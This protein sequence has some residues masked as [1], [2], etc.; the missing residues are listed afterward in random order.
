[1]SI[2]R[3]DEKCRTRGGG[4]R[5]VAYCDPDSCYNRSKKTLALR[6]QLSAR[7][8][9][10]PL[11]ALFHA[12]PLS[13]AE[14]RALQGQLARLDAY[15]TKADGQCR[16]VHYCHRTRQGCES[17]SETARAARSKLAAPQGERGRPR[18]ASAAASSSREVRRRPAAASA[19]SSSR[20]A[21][22][23]PAAAPSSSDRVRQP[24]PPRQVDAPAGTGPRQQRGLSR[25]EPGQGSSASDAR[26]ESLEDLRARAERLIAGEGTSSGSE[27]EGS[28]SGSRGEGSSSGSRGEGS[29]SG[30][31]GEG[32]SSGSRGEGS[33]SAQASADRP[34][35]IY[36]LRGPMGDDIA[37]R[38]ARDYLDE[39]LRRV[40]T[41]PREMNAAHTYVKLCADLALVPCR[42][43]R[44]EKDPYD[45]EEFSREELE[46]NCVAYRRRGAHDT[47]MRP[48]NW[49]QSIISHPRHHAIDP[50]TRELHCGG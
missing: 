9:A 23:R 29:S 13:A 4:C 38:R 11:L 17:R 10:H 43:E 21:R 24:G 15:C 22:R 39:S 18:P 8:A 27:G 5:Q 45:Q 33:S 50:M 6:L 35:G 25:M 2:R 48:S 37:Y 44:C 34:P 1:M 42:A 28:S 26:Q 20:E 31:R 12:P 32:S 19:S 16:S 47:C 7:N 30:S 40:H 14:R 3:E 41:S 49:V 46:D 36:R